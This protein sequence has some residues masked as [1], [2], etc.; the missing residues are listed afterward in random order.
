VICFRGI[1]LDLDFDPKARPKVE[2]TEAPKVPTQFFCLRSSLA[3]QHHQQPFSPL[4]LQVTRSLDLNSFS[5]HHGATSTNT[6]GRFTHW[7]CQSPKSETQNRRKE[8]GCLHYNGIA[9][10]L[11]VFRVQ[12]L[13]LASRWLASPVWVKPLSSTPSS[14]P[15]SR[16]IRITND[17]T[18][19]RSTRPSKSRSQRLSWK[20]SSSKVKDYNSPHLQHSLTFTRS[21]SDRH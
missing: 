7:H 19:S 13:I 18:P 21:S 10:P 9:W 2:E 15:P 17:G 1:L 12:S 3:Q 5:D 20:R 16:T 4:V 11:R 14:Q 8:G 6:R